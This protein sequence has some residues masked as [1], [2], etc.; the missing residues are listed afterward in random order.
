MSSRRTQEGP[1]DR[2]VRVI[3]R[4]IPDIAE[5]D[6]IELLL[7]TA[8]RGIDRKQNRPGYAAT[9]KADNDDDLEESE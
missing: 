1:R 6:S 3:P 8:A 2:R 5:S 7:P 4:R 9:D